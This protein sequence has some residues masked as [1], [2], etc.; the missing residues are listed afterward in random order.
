MKL[1]GSVKKLNKKTLFILFGIEGI[2]FTALRF[3]QMNSLT[4]PETGFFTDKGNVTVILFYALWFVTVLG[5]MLLFYLASDCD[6]GAYSQ[7]KNIPLAIGSFIMAAGAAYDVFLRVADTQTKAGGL[8]FSDYI[9]IEKAYLAVGCIIFAALSALVFLIDAISFVTGSGYASSLKL[10]HLFPVLWLFCVTVCYFSITVSYLNVSQLMLMIFA[11]GFLMVFLFEYARFISG[12]GAKEAPWL[13]F[14]SGVTAE[15]LLVASELP[16]LA[17]TLMKTPEKLVANCPL[18]VYD[19][20]AVVFVA[21]ALL[22]AAQ[23]KNYT[24]VRLEPLNA[25]AG[26]GS[27][28][29]EGDKKESENGTAE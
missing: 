15:I 20:A 23:N 16:N 24:A 3:F 13:L 26:N 28:E 12:I 27:S 11:D 29:T 17:F 22:S 7:R 25:E 10:C 1:K 8:D 9:R 19:L 5:T 6:T 21:L 2:L 18:N 14:A 4:N